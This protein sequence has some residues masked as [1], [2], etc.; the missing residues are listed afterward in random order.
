MARI[1]PM[2]L[3][4]VPEHVRPLLAPDL[5]RFG[6]VS[7]TTGVYAYAPSILEGARALDAGIT[8]VGGISPELRCLVNVRV[9]TIVGC[10][11]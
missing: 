10:P 3:D 8:G 7:P 11:F 2:G 9:A 6:V 4:D 1:R 5:Q